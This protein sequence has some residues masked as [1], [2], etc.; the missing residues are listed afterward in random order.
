MRCIYQ[1]KRV[2]Q[3]QTK[4]RPISKHRELF[5]GKREP[6][7]HYASFKP[8][9]FFR[10]L[11]QPPFRPPAACI[12]P[13]GWPMPIRYVRIYT[14]NCASGEIA[15]ANGN[16][17]FGHHAFEGQAEGRVETYTLLDASIEIGQIAN[18]FPCGK[19]MTKRG[20]GRTEFRIQPCHCFRMGQQMEPY[21][22]QDN[23]SGIRPGNNV[24]ECPCCYGPGKL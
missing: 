14:Y 2:V 6:Y 15:I 17:S 5:I 11:T 3:H 12:L 22:P 19:G 4:R 16:T 7:G 9:L 21:C 20:V 24:G 18:L 1:G 8:P 13:K 23:A 10:A